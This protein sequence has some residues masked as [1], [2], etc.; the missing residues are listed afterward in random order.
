MD[1]TDEFNDLLKKLTTSKEAI[2][3]TTKYALD[4]EYFADDLFDILLKRLKKVLLFFFKLYLK[5]KKKNLTFLS[6]KSSFKR[7]LSLLYL[8]DSLAQNAKI[9]DS[10]DYLELISQRLSI[11][12]RYLLFLKSTPKGSNASLSSLPNE[13]EEARQKIIQALKKVS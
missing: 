8:L 3:K 1:P 6:F 12:I 7:K 5:T 4:Y 2:S 11:V 9:K 10:E 13:E